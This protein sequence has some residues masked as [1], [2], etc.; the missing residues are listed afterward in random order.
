MLGGAIEVG[1]RNV[2]RRGHEGLEHLLHGRNSGDGEST[3]RRAV[4]RHFAGN[5][6]GLKGLTLKLPILLG[7]LP[8]RLVSL[9]TAGRKEDAVQVAGRVVGEA[10]GKLD[11][12]RMSV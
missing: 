4:I 11:G 9:T 3:L 5:H 8:R 6:F 1:I 2:V 10:V 7:Q 12:R